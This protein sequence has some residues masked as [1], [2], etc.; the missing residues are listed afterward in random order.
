MKGQLRFDEFMNISEEKPKQETSRCAEQRIPMVDPCYYCLCNSCI[1]NAESTTVNLG[2]DNFSDDWEECFFCGEC[3]K[4]DGDT[5]KETWKG[6]NAP[7][8]KLIIIMQ[9]RS[10]KNSR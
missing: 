8:M 9:N 10:E 6:N 3:R 2:N 1:N 5:K 7:D 4:F